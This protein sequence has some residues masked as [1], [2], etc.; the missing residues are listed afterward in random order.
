MTQLSRRASRLR[1]GGNSVL[2]D[3]LLLRAGFKQQRKLVETLNASQQLGAVDEI[4][5]QR[6]L[7]A[8]REIQK[9]ILNI[10]WCLL[11]IH[12]TFALKFVRL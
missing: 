9:T 8:A 2:E 4:N 1:D 12:E 5:R 7:L 3:Q 10:L 11:G 6:R